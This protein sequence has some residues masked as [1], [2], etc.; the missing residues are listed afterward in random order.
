MKLRRETRAQ[1]HRQV[2]AALARH[3]LTCYALAG[4]QALLLSVKS[5]VIPLAAAVVENSAFLLHGVVVP[6]GDAVPAG[7]RLGRLCAAHC[8]QG[9][10][11]H[12]ST[13]G[14]RKTED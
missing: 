3:R 4:F 1:H 2:R 10:R 7:P 8:K 12:V 9:E 13:G 11:G 5:V 6:L 14:R